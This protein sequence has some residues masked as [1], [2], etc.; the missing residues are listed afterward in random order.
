MLDRLE[1]L[2]TEKPFHLIHSVDS[3]GKLIGPYKKELNV[4]LAADISGIQLD[5]IFG[6]L[7]LTE[8]TVMSYLKTS[9]SVTVKFLKSFFGDDHRLLKASDG[10]FVASPQQKDILELYYLIPSRRIYVIPYGINTQE[11][12]PSKESEN[13]FTKWG[14][15]PGTKVILTSTPLLNV[16]ETKNLLTAFVKVVI[17]KPNTTL[18]I[19]GDGPKRKD[20]EFHM[21]SLALAS[22]VV[23]TG[24][25]SPIEE[26]VAI[27]KC[28]IYVNLSSKSSGFEGSV[29]EAMA[30]RKMVIASEVGTS[31]NLIK[32]GVDGFLLRPTEIASLTRLLLEAVSGQ[33]DTETIGRMAREKILKMFDTQ[34]MVTETIG[35]YRQILKSTGKYRKS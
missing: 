20:L 14:I 18:V 24:N 17:K 29:L 26:D 4:A 2:H 35:A 25:I 8:D 23:F 7:G 31:A 9:F 28:D 3:S 32:S 5:Q 33:I 21:L 15:A 12:E 22:K 30:C 1:Q 10:V 34:A 13:V 27:N 19:A 11:L 16:E 6:I